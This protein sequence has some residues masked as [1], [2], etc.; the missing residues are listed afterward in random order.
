MYIHI[1]TKNSFIHTEAHITQRN[2]II[3]RRQYFI[4]I[5]ENILNLI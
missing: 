5:K 2:I 4:P 1:Q 3:D